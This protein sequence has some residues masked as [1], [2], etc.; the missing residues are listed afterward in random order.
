MNDSRLKPKARNEKL[1]NE[2]LL[3]M[4]HTQTNARVS[5]CGL[6]FRKAYQTS[7]Q[8]EAAKEVGSPPRALS[9]FAAARPQ[10]NN[11][12]AVT[13]SGVRRPGRSRSGFSDSRSHTIPVR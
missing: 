1:F 11:C 13:R 6:E 4:L 3:I 7:C 8:D 9:R 2:E 12:K 5:D 10:H